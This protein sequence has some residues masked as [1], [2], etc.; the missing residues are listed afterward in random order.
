MDRLLQL[1]PFIAGG[2]NLAGMNGWDRL[3][4]AGT[5]GWNR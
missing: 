5:A 3:G 1:L 4:I 2:A